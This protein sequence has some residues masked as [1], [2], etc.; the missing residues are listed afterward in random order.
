MADNVRI[1]RR[2]FLRGSALVATTTL[3]AACAPSQTAAPPKPA[4]SKPA[5]SKPAAAPTTAAAGKPAEAAKPAETKPGAGEPKRGGQMSLAII[6]DPTLN[7]FTWPGQFS[8]VMAAKP[9]WSTLIKYEPGTMRAVPDL[10]TSW[11]PAPDGLAWTFKLRQGVTWHD[12]A[13]FTAADVKFTIDNIMN[14]QVNALFRSNLVGLKGAEVVDDRTARLVLDKPFSSLP[15]QLGYNIA[16]APK[17][18]LDGKD[19]NSLDEYV[20]NPIG[21]G[22]F[23][24]REIVKGSHIAMEAFPDYYD[25]RPNLDGMVF[26][27]IPEINTQVAQLRTGELDLA[28][29]EPPHK[30]TL[31]NQQNLQFSTVEQPNTF[32]FC[33][34][35]SREPFNDKRVRLALTLGCNRQLMVERILRGEAPVAAGAYGTAFGEFQNKELKPYPYDPERAKQLLAEAGWQ[36]GADG[37]MEK[38]GK[39]MSFGF[40]VD[41]GNPTREQMALALQQD[42][43]RIGVDIQIDVQEFNVYLRRGNSR[44]GDYDARTGWR[45]TAPDPDKTSEYTTEGTNNHYM[46]SNPEVDR[47]MEQ[48]KAE[49]DQNKRKEIYH[50]IQ[51]IMYDDMPIIWVYYW[52]EIIALNRAINGLPEMGI[53]DSL[54]YTHKLW[55]A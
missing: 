49:S 50:R 8:T 47:L 4:E 5:E 39:R 55:R 33:L 37:I 20:Q 1:S 7:P 51:Q 23:R 44:P 14:P 52:T 53:R 38:D 41:K 21:T 15:I 25:G 46:Y 19:L 30:E 11:E 24:I 31:R 10:A 3:L 35:N 26:K 18:L 29:I 12:G 27:I 16:M 54:T 42:W 6:S 36:P 17:H 13:P 22:P 34:N 40:M 2:A 9:L 43:K 45:I 28:L 32:Y 48:G